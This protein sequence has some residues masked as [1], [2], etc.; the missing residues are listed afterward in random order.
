MTNSQ[1][2]KATWLRLALASALLIGI[3]GTALAPSALA[4]EGS[5]EPSA[6][7]QLDEWEQNALAHAVTVVPVSFVTGFVSGLTANPA[8]GAT[9][10]GSLAA[11]ISITG[12]NREVAKQVVNSVGMTI[13]AVSTAYSETNRITEG[14]TNVAGGLSGC[15]Q[16][17]IRLSG[18]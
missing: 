17:A 2:Y 13:D 10:G 11:A 12:A 1:T 3:F 18:C 4:D 7:D 5:S 8:I 16:S 14:G 6:W 15:I 9:A